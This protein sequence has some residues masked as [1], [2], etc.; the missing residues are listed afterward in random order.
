MGSGG[1]RQ[2]QLERRLDEPASFVMIELEP[3]K[4]DTTLL[5][6]IDKYGDRPVSPAV[7]VCGTEYSGLLVL[8]D[9]AMNILEHGPEAS[10]GDS[11]RELP[12]VRDTAPA[13]EAALLMNEHDT[14]AIAV[15]NEKNIPVGIVS[16]MSLAGLNTSAIKDSTHKGD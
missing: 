5:E 1:E 8:H 6:V 12:A 16:A 10:A 14:A 4:P 3:L 2:G 13:L 11:M 7:A 15:V 9:V